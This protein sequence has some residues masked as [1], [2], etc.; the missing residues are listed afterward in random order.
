VAAGGR[1]EPGALGAA[2]DDLKEAGQEG[3]AEALARAKL[4]LYLSF[5]QEAVVAEQ[6]ADPTARYPEPGLPRGARLGLLGRGYVTVADGPIYDGPGA[7]QVGEVLA[8]IG[9]IPYGPRADE[10]VRQTA[11]L[12]R[13]LGRRVLVAG[14]DY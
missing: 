12:L 4:T 7:A 3:A 11:G 8:W 13:L 5:E 10:A 9:P 14:T 2:T 1:G 6:E